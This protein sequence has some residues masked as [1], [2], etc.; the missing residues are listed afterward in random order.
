MDAVVHN[1]EI[2]PNS[3]PAKS[4]SKSF[5]IPKQHY[6]HKRAMSEHFPYRIIIIYTLSILENKVI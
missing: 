1:L 3:C 4:I 5:K 6:F 2:W